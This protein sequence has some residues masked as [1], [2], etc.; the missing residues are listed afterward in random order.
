MKS[1]YYQENLSNR[2]LSVFNVKVIDI[3]LLIALNTV[4]V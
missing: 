4:F 3:F 1:F 2:P